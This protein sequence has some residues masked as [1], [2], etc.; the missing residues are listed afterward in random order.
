NV[1]VSETYVIEGDHLRRTG[2]EDLAR[3]EG[4]EGCYKVTREIL[5]GGAL[6]EVCRQRAP[7][8][9]SEE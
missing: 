9:D 5:P 7:D 1:P 8:Q 3:G 6:R 2:Q 4:E